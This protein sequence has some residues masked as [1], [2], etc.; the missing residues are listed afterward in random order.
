MDVLIHTIVCVDG[1]NSADSITTRVFVF[2]ENAKES[3]VMSWKNAIVAMNCLSIFFTACSFGC[4]S[5]TS[6]GFCTATGFTFTYNLPLLFKIGEMYLS[7]N[8]S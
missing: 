1:S 6:N 4:A 7:S 2:R 8:K 5:S 3:R